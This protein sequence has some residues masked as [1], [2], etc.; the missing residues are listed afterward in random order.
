MQSNKFDILDIL[1][2]K[3]VLYAE[4]EEGI[5]E[6]I[7]DILELFFNKV[8]SVKNGIEALSEISNNSYDVLIFDVSMPK[9]NGIEAIRKI[10]KTNRKIPI[11][12]LSAH[13]EQEYLWKAVELKITKYLA[14]PCDKDTLVN[15]LKQA[16]LELTDF[17]KKIKLYENCTYNPFDR[18]L[19]FNE[20]SIKLSKNESRLLEYFIKHKNQIVTFDKI[21]SYLWG[22]DTPSKEAIKFIIK[23]LRKKIGKN[24]IKNIYGEG[25][26]FKNTQ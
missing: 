11:I 23:G 1:C 9:L 12:I 26:I 14:K 10:R 25:Y 24:M 18:T 13:T 5:R 16:C 15:A 8:V 17:N 7:V 3:K 2:D 21:Y 6:V 19:N 22:F 4:D 20:N